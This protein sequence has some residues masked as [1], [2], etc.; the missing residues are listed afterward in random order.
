MITVNEI[1]ITIR[2]R[3][4]DMNKISFSDAELIY[5]LNNA[6]DRLSAELISQFNPEMIQKFTVKGQDGGMKPD[7]FVAVR[8]QYPI[9]WKTQS[10]F[11]VKAVPL[12]SDYDED[13]EV[14]YFARRP[15][16]E[17]LENTIPFTDPVHQKTL[18]TYTL[19]DIKPSSENSQGA[20]NDG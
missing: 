16:V 17:K 5:C 12:D 14:S 11:S 9:E 1:L 4:G 6:I 2:Q 8:G 10:D 7:D 18:V 3:L 13:I 19:Y 20:N 15:H